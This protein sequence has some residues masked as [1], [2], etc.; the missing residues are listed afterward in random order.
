MSTKPVRVTYVWCSGKDTHHDL[1]SKDKTM[2]LTEEQLAKTPQ[3]LVDAGVFPEW[4]FDGSSTE[5]AKGLDTEILIRP[6]RAWNNVLPTE[7]PQVRRYIVLAECFLPNG[8]PTAD[9]TRFLARQVFAEDKIGYKPWYGMEQEMVLVDATKN[10]PVG[11]P[12]DG[13]PQ[14]G[15]AHV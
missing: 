12:H 14:I 1:R 11:W 4:N 3:E 6:V 5:Q 2:Y 10:W 9:N 8:Q 15:R 7:A 13:F